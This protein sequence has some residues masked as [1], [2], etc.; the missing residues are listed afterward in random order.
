MGYKLKYVP[1]TAARRLHAPAGPSACS[2]LPIP[3]L[4]RSLH[5]TAQDCT[6]QEPAQDC[7]SS[8]PLQCSLQSQH[9]HTAQ[10][11]QNSVCSTQQHQKGFLVMAIQP[12]KL[13]AN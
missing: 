8:D 11:A 7:S 3:A 12:I 5:S 4:H 2:M 13:K 1:I 9:R 10:G 6:A